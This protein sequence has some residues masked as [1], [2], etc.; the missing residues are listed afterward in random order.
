MKTVKTHSVVAY[1]QT[2][3]EIVF[4]GTK[5]EC[6]AFVEKNAFYF[7]NPIETCEKLI[8]GFDDEYFS[9]AEIASAPLCF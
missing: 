9:L 2:S 5:S 1:S 6:D 4:N 7:P 3:F 8:D